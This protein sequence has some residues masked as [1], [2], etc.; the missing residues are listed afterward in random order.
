MFFSIL[1]WLTGK[2]DQLTSKPLFE[3]PSADVKLTQL[4]WMFTHQPCRRPSASFKSWTAPLSKEQSHFS[5]YVCR[6]L[7][8]KVK[9]SSNLHEKSEWA[10]VQFSASFR[11]L[12][13]VFT[14]LCRKHS[15]SSLLFHSYV[16]S[17]LLWN[18]KGPYE[19]SEW[20]LIPW[21]MI[22]TT[23][24]SKN[25]SALMRFVWDGRKF[26]LFSSKMVNKT[27]LVCLE[28]NGTCLV[29]L[30][31]TYSFIFRSICSTVNAM[32]VIVISWGSDIVMFDVFKI[33]HLFSTQIGTH[34]R[35]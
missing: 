9:R 6:R 13:A 20:R 32:I 2:V 30:D 31:Y 8:Q 28:T 14:I 18:T 1:L 15:D 24:Q 16:T 29:V 10:R 5:F 23:K 35:K 12:D 19:D 17:S 25:W 4:R 27:I 33:W 34:F 21:R 7:R 3:N 11:T 22:R 26:E